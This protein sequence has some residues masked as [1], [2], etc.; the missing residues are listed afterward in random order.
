MKSIT[1]LSTS[2][3]VATLAFKANEVNERGVD[4]LGFDTPVGLGNN[5]NSIAIHSR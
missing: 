2:G 4:S 1:N 5:S 3:S